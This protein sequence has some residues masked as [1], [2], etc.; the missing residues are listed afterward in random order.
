MDYINSLENSLSLKELIR[1]VQQELIESQKERQEKGDPSLFEV[2]KLTLEINFVVT[3]S[4]GGKGSFEV[5][6]LTFG[7]FNLGG[8]GN[9][10][11]QKIHK[12][13]L[14][15]KA[16]PPSKTAPET[17]GGGGGGGG[18]GPQD[19]LHDMAS[20]FAPSFPDKENAF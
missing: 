7:G 6:V 15:L 9:F 16:V 14:S 19:H 4:Q 5:K 20:G 12:I 13:T 11:Q 17:S 8:E 10:Q 1:G 3:R 2:E 18:R